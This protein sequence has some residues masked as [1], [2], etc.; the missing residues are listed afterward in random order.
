MSATAIIIASSVGGL[1]TTSGWIVRWWDGRRDRKAYNTLRDNF[2]SQA[3]QF[4]NVKTE[5]EAANHS[6]ETLK[7]LGEAPQNDGYNAA[8]FQ[9]ILEEL[10]KH[11]GPSAQL[12]LDSY[13]TGLYPD[14]LPDHDGK[15]PDRKTRPP[16]TPLPIATE[17]P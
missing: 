12:L 5:L 9:Y 17:L 7:L 10:G 2:D 8:W 16:G 4:N 11:D 14:D 6:V 1:V 15:S 3:E 13:H